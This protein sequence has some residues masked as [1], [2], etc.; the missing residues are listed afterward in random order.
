MARILLLY[1]RDYCGH[2]SVIVRHEK[3]ILKVFVF[4]VMWS[5]IRRADW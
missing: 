3:L 2:N 1:S 4:Q 5:C